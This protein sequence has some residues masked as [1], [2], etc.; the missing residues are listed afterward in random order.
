M[1]KI[2]FVDYYTQVK[3]LESD[4]IHF[5]EIQIENLMHYE[6][7]LMKEI[8]FWVVGCTIYIN[9]KKVLLIIKKK[10]LSFFECVE[11]CSL[12]DSQKVLFL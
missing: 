12:N 2:F 3:K 5:K 11:N 4:L 6:L 9:L 10:C 8:I 7:I 1:S